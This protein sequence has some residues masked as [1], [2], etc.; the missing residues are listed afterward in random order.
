MKSL[1]IY[2]LFSFL[3]NKGKTAN[4]GKSPA[5]AFGLLLQKMGLKSR[6]AVENTKLFQEPP[7]QD[8]IPSVSV[9]ISPERMTLVQK[10]SEPHPAFAGVKH[11]V[12][13]KQATTDKNQITTPEKMAYLREEL[14]P[15]P[16]AG[17]KENHQTSLK[18]EAPIAV[19]TAMPAGNRGAGRSIQAKPNTDSRA[20]TAQSKMLNPFTPLKEKISGKEHM[21][22][23]GKSGTHHQ[24]SVAEKT[25]ASVKEHPV[26][27]SNR[28]PVEEPKVQQSN[29]V[30]ILNKKSPPA[31]PAESEKGNQGSREVKLTDVA[32]RKTL[33][34]IKQAMANPFRKLFGL[35]AKASSVSGNEL[36]SAEMVDNKTRVKPKLV[37]R[38]YV[39]AESKLEMEHLP[40]QPNRQNVRSPHPVF[41]DGVQ[42]LNNKTI[43]VST[44]KVLIRSAEQN[45]TAGEGIWQKLFQKLL[46]RPQI[47]E[48]D[49]RTA[50]NT[51]NVRERRGRIESPLP[52]KNE[53]HSKPLNIPV[54]GD[55]SS[56]VSWPDS[57]A[58]GINKSKGFHSDQLRSA[59]GA[60]PA[61]FAPV[62]SSSVEALKPALHWPLVD[63]ILQFVITTHNGNLNQAVLK[64][65]N[66]ALG[67]MEIHFKEVAKN[68]EVTL[69][70]ENETAKSEVERLLPRI[71]EA[72]Q[73][74]GIDLQSLKVDIYHY[75][76]KD[77]QD[78]QR[79]GRPLS[80]TQNYHEEVPDELKSS[81]V[82]IRQYGYNTIEV[83]A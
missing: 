68:K 14:I 30:V 42:T 18:D 20:D 38:P 79:A 83:I 34:P 81:T 75:S 47:T 44:G 37:T 41:R 27:N 65:D 49:L 66:T 6:S 13:R 60:T 78:R 45:P 31:V 33:W 5:M 72:L 21:P 70:V 46:K 10:E 12:S 67:K 43:V 11:I 16:M 9:N 26:K 61:A 19:V 22:F 71:N 53:G 64:I 7:G 17:R 59:G 77:E 8:R 56:Q 48:P 28:I 40:H 76:R 57:E 4:P 24:V 55:Q 2:N 29:P 82:K 36:S 25:I 1:R 35:K 15:K 23:P 58:A 74:R 39:Q 63:R 69:L 73:Q 51:G 54:R 80:S 32:D 52:T 3:F 62:G 50:E